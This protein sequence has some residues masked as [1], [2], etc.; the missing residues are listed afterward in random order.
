MS[1]TIV[2]AGFHLEGGPGV[3]RGRRKRAIRGA[4]LPRRAP[5][6][7]AGPRERRP[8]VSKTARGSD[9]GCFA[10][11]A[12]GTRPLPRHWIQRGRLRYY[13]DSTLPIGLGMPSRAETA[14]VQAESPR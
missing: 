12:A 13:F 7:E 2:A 14:S 1:T 6:R 3:E 5:P 4:R 11:A 9:G 10:L 8:P